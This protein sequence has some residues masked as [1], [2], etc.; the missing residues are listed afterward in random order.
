VVVIPCPNSLEGYIL[1][2]DSIWE[3][4][5]TERKT[6]PFAGDID[7]TVV[8]KQTHT[9]IV[10]MIVYTCQVNM[11]V[12]RVCTFIIDLKSIISLLMIP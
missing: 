8:A 1:S 7:I 12:E 6:I 5:N 4:V 2:G 3:F 9:H 11:T 10:L